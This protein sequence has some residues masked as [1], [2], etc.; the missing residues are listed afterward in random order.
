MEKRRTIQE[1]EDYATQ[2]WTREEKKGREKH[3]CPTRRLASFIILVQSSVPASRLAYHPQFP[4]PT[5]TQN[6]HP[7]YLAPIMRQGENMEYEK[8]T[9]KD[10]I[11]NNNR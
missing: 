11:K 10:K 1:A 6:P 7:L 5:V 9:N 4:V 2:R 3:V 8:S